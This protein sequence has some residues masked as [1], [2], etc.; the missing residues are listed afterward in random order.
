MSRIV[1]LFIIFAIITSQYSSGQSGNATSSVSEVHLKSVW[2]NDFPD[3]IAPLESQGFYVLWDVSVPM[4][5]YIHES[6]ASL[7][8]ALS[9][10]QELLKNGLLNSDYRRST[11][12]CMTIKDTI[13]LMEKCDNNQ[14]RD[15]SFFLGARSDL[16]LGVEFVIDS[17]KAGKIMGAAL[18][19]DLMATTEYGTGATALLRYFEDEELKAYFTDGQIYMGIVG[20]APDY[21]GIKK[22]GCLTTTGPLGCWF[23]EG[24][25]QW[26]PLNEVIKRPI[27]VLV[28]G[29]R[30]KGEDKY[31]NSVNTIIEQLYGDLN[32]LGYEVKFERMTLGALGLKTNLTWQNPISEDQRRPPI[33]LNSESGFSCYNRDVHTVSSKFENHGIII[34][35]ISADITDNL[36][37]FNQVRKD[38]DSGIKLDLDCEEVLNVVRKERRCKD[39]D[40]DRPCNCTTDDAIFKPHLSMI[41]A[42]LSYEAENTMNWDEWSSI[43]HSDSLTLYLTDFIDGLKPS[44]YDAM[45]SPV[46]PLDCSRAKR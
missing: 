27:Y 10:I 26:L 29:R 5:G 7:S 39:G 30:L 40:P 2:E 19:T 25:Q 35:E 4:G 41:T 22:G 6:N 1:V 16:G 21:W 20:I 17:L 14:L 43:Q 44:Y 32:D 8:V 11:L 18:I 34:D 42:R 9:K 33:S 28:L 37:T 15:R 12:Q 36:E 3:L 38:G 13:S 46:P 24:I 45:I 23:H 31:T